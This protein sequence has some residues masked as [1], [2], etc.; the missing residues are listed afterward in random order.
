MFSNLAIVVFGTLRVNIMSFF[1]GDIVTVI[2]PI[3]PDH[4]LC[5]R[6]VAMAGEKVTKDNGDTIQVSL[7]ENTS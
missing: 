3:E 2:K 6:V 4:I 1:R 5:K 7:P